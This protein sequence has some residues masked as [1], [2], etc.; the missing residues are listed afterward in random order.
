MIDDA[1]P[2]SRTH[3]A[4]SAAV[5]PHAICTRI[6]VSSVSSLLRRTL[7]KVVSGVAAVAVFCTIPSKVC[8]QMLVTSGGVEPLAEYNP[9]TGAVENAALVLGNG[10]ETPKN[11]ASAGG[12]IYVS[13]IYSGTIGEYDATTGAVVNAAFISGASYPD[14]M[15]VSGGLLYVLEGNASGNNDWISVYDATTGA[16]VNPALVSG[17][18]QVGTGLAIFGGNLYVTSTVVG[19]IA[20]YNAVTGAVVNAA[21]VSGL[22]GPYGIAECG[23]KLFVVNIGSGTIGEYDATTGAVVNAA[24]ISGLSTPID[25]AVYR[26]NLYVSSYGATATTGTI[27]EYNIDGTTVNAALVSGLDYPAYIAFVTPDGPPGAPGPQGPAGPTGPTGA[28]GA[29]GAAGATGPAGSA[30]AVGATGATGAAGPQG[31]A[32]PAGPTGATGPIG[33][34]GPTGAIGPVG[35]QGT[36]GATGAQGPQGVSGPTGPQGP[37]GPAAP[38]GVFP[39]VTVTA[40]VTLT[41]NNTVVLVDSTSGNVTVTLPDATANSGRYYVIKRTVAANKVT[42]QPQSGQTIEG[43]PNT[44]LTGAGSTDTIISNGTRWVRISFINNP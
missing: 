19:T 13:Y 17:L 11:F 18:D 14:A 15:A 10:I 34:I 38:I 23:G 42:I 32:G 40:S 31:I 2:R 37:T 25:I 36:P 12:R 27:G 6:S 28:T 9:A 29:T 20:E 24:L 5:D 33:P 21:L 4:D 8:G 22:N 26:E 3:G 30:G 16:V 41:A 44:A 39:I 7:A 1:G 35:P 43:N